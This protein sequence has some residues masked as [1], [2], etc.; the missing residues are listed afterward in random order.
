MNSFFPKKIFRVGVDFDLTMVDSLWPWIQWFNTHLERMNAFASCDGSQ[1]AI[2]ITHE[3]YLAFPG[4]Q[5]AD[6]MNERQAHLVVEDRLNP[7]AYWRQHD[8]YDNMQP[9]A[10][11][12]EFFTALQKRMMTYHGFMDVEFVCVTKCEP[13]H[14]LSKRRFV[15]T[16]FSDLF[17][18]FVSTDD[19]HLVSMDC[20]IDDNPKYVKP[21]NENGIFQIYVPQGQVK[22]FTHV[23]DF[24]EEYFTVAPSAE[25]ENHFGY[26]NQQVDA[27]ADMLGR[28]YNYIR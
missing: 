8:L 3:C 13:E 15:E 22:E 4:E 7:M 16:H 26:L 6:L 11:A 18:G 5:L 12:R 1:Q 28:H 25:F 27:I 14:E 23:D 24:C 19:K 2:L 21:C 10:G 17:N 20:L 9:L